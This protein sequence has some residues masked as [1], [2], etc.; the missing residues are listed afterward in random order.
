MGPEVQFLFMTL[1]LTAVWTWAGDQKPQGLFSHSY[2][3]S[4]PIALCSSTWLFQS[5]CGKELYHIKKPWENVVI[6][7]NTFNIYVLFS[8]WK[9]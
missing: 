5:T 8:L 3:I 1:A 2:G 4:Y 9:C 7:L 6:R